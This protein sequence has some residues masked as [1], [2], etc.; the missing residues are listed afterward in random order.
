MRRSSALV[1]LLV[2]VVGTAVVAACVPEP[3]PPTPPPPTTVAVYGDSL[4]VQS[5][6][7]LARFYDAHN[8][9]VQPQ[10]YAGTAPCDF[11]SAMMN[12]PL[13]AKVVI[14]FSGNML[15][16]CTRNRGTLAEVYGVDLTTMA[17]YF[18]DR[19][20]PVVLMSAPTFVGVHEDD[21]VAARV[22][23]QVAA[24]FAA[25]GAQYVNAADVLTDTTHT[26]VRTLPCE[27]T[28]VDDGLCVAGV[29]VVRADD[30]MHLSP[31]GARRWA[32]RIVEAT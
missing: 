10:Y 7:Q 19:G 6:E 28:D 23:A 25:S 12:A 15:T 3:T 17:R 29:A 26:Y 5:A 32:H 16:L 27:Q 30:G 4:L 11:M 24:N 8:V 22:A 13:P 14:A 21:N 9:V 18:T 2:G 20:V 1:R 31:S